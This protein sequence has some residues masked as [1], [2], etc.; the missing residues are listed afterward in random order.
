M[1][2]EIEPADQAQSTADDE[3]DPGDK[4]GLDRHQ[5]NHPDTDIG[6]GD[7]VP[8]WHRRIWVRLAL[9]FV[10]H[11]AKGNGIHLDQ[12]L[13]EDTFAPLARNTRAL[14]SCGRQ[15]TTRLIRQ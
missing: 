15:R 6:S 10:S 13:A 5:E 7:P 2:Q 8:Q 3:R 1:A 4:A 9:V 14:R 11:R 12:V